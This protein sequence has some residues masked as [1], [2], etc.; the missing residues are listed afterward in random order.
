MTGPDFVATNLVEQIDKRRRII[1]LVNF[2]AEHNPSVQSISI[3]CSAVEGESPTAVTFYSP[4]S[5][6][7]RALEFRMQNSQAV[8]SVPTLKAYG[9]ITVSW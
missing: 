9:V 1:H 2:D 6:G 7:A 5:D 4:E 3:R 8:F